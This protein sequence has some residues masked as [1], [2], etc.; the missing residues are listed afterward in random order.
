MSPDFETSVRF[1]SPAQGITAKR[2]LANYRGFVIL[3][4]MEPSLRRQKNGEVS[5]SKLDPTV[6][7]T[8]VRFALDS[9]VEQASMDV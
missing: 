3:K 7:L 9:I 1:I 6:L 8:F 5:S 2:D 4:R